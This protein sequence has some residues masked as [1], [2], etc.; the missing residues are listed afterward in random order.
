MNQQS[1][2]IDDGTVG[3]LYLVPTPIGNLEDMT[4]RAVR[5]LKEV[6][7]IAAEDTRQT[8]KLCRHFDIDTALISYHEHNKRKAGE[9]LIEKIKAGNSIALVS[10]AGMPAISD[11]GQDIA[12]EAIKEGIKVIA[13]PGANAALTSLVASGLSTER[14]EFIGFLPRQNKQRQSFLEEIKGDKAT[15]I[16]YESPHRLK[17]SLSSMYKVLGNRHL[18]ISR[19]LTKKFEEYQRGTLEEA[20]QWCETGTIKGEFCI[21]VEGCHTE[22]VKDEWW[23][24]ISMQQHV[25]HYVGLG[26]TSKEAIKQVALERNVQKRLV[27]AEYHQD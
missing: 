17:E 8:M 26:M 20:I 18:S 10:D 23:E 21:V 22:E 24:P 2:F 13:L 19:E 1:S 9:V 16:F 25:E 27:Y 3:L 12:Q 14:F 6:D 15:L 11:P 4:F 7:L 5:I